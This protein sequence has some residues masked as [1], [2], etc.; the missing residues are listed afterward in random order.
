MTFGVTIDGFVTKRLSDVKTEIESALKSVLGNGVNLTA[1][2]PLGQIV[3]ILAEREAELWELA[4][5]VYNSQYPDTSFGVPLD[6]AVALTGLARQPA[7][8]SKVLAVALAGD[9]GTLISAGSILSVAGDSTARFLLDD[10]VTLDGGGAGVGDFTAESSGPVS[11][12]ATSLSVIETPVSGWDTASN[13]TDANVGKAVETDP[14]LKL[15]RIQSLRRAGAA[16]V[17]AIRADVLEVDGVTGCTV[18]ENTDI[19]T[20]GD[21]NP[22]KSFQAIVSGGDDDAIALAIWETKPAGIQAYGSTVV[23]V[24][25]SQGFSHDVGFSRPEDLDIYL[26][27]DLTTDLS[28]PVGG[29]DLVKDAIIAYNATLSLGDDVIVYPKLISSLNDIPGILDVGIKIGTAPS[30][31]LDDNITVTPFQVAAFDTSRI[32]VNS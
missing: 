9:P 13:P 15:R 4:E 28:Y 32:T 5:G 18:L 31:T 19:V 2:S 29:D 12:P 1:E 8:F 16:T 21:G 6:N 22:P 11:A 10:P 14:E 20:D 25:D 24:T 26:I 17:E 7:T 27:L 30:P 23:A 3:G